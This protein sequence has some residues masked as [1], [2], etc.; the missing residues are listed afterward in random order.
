MEHD[1]A[2]KAAYKA[3][4][5]INSTRDIKYF[6]TLTKSNGNVITITDRDAV[7]IG[8]GRAIL[9]L[10]MGTQLVIEDELL[11]PDSTRTL[12]SYKDIRRNGFHIETHDDN[13]NEYLFITKHDGYTKQTL[14]KIP[15]LSTGL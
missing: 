8:S 11:Y 12:L 6:Q 9:I 7:I 1:D 4:F 5:R 3:V 2:Y 10:P 13:N 14:E 15:S